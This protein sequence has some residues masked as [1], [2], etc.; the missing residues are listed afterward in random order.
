M[1][2]ISPKVR[3][4]LPTPP[5]LNNLFITTKSG[6]RAPSKRYSQWR[7][8]AAQALYMG[9]KR[10]EG[11]VTIK[12]TVEDKGRRDLDNFCKSVLDFCVTHRVIEGD[13]REFVRKITI[14]W[15][16]V[17]GAVVEIEPIASLATE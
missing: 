6:H 11:P 1:R 2:I 15:G 16:D 17:K 4:E 3:L 5:S 12:I 8:I 10:L 13:S 14:E 9:Y 7:H